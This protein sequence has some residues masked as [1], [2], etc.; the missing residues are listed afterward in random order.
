MKIEEKI[1]RLFTQV[2]E[3]YG[4]NKKA[5]AD[6]LGINAVTFWG[7]VKSGRGMTMIRPLLNAVERAGGFTNSR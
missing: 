4:G 2:I 7:W 1:Q 3:K 6:S 5:A